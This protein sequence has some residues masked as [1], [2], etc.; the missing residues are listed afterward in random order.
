MEH[1]RP[2]WHQAIF[3]ELGTANQQKL[4][5]KIDVLPTQSGHLANAQP[6]T[7]QQSEDHL[8]DL[9]PAL[10][11]WVTG[12]S[13]CNFEKAARLVW[14]EEERPES[15]RDAPSFASQRRCRQQ[16]VNHHPVEQP[17][18]GA[19]EP[20]VATWRVP[21]PGCYEC[22][23]VRRG[24]RAEFFDILSKQIAVQPMKHRP[25]LG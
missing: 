6:Q 15:W 20:V 3:A 16:F 4:F 25:H 22:I 5:I 14:V 10:R 8:V 2:E 23:Y 13:F 24:N 9:S 11:S 17:S 18:N 19:D 7:I 21:R 12:Q 1:L